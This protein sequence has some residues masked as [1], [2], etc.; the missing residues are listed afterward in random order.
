MPIEVGIWRIDQQLQRVPFSALD[1][2]SRLEH[3]LVKEIS[4]LSPGLMVIGQQ[5]PTAHGHFIDI[6]AMDAD[7]NLI[8]VELKRHRTPREVVAQVLDYASWVQTLSYNDIA[9]L[10]AARNQGDEFEQGFAKAFGG[11]P[12]EKL[13][14]QMRLI[15]VAAELDHASERIIGFLAD[16]YGVPI[17]AVYFRYFKDGDHEYLARTWLIDPQEAEAKIRSKDL[18]EPWNGQ[19][20]YVSYGDTGD[21]DLV[22]EDARNYGFITADGGRWYTRTLERL[23]VGAR[24]FVCIPGSGYVGVGTVTDTVQPISD[25]MV[26]VSGVPTPFVDAPLAGT[27]MKHRA[28]DPELR[29]YFVRVEWIK[30]LPKQDAYWET[31]MYANQNTVTR[32]RNRFTLERLI[33]HFELDAD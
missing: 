29:A 5:V 7:G 17:N 1:S 6:L 24:V 9:E 23:F 15:V 21:N 25:F 33:Q 16:N 12:P 11:N 26:D 22:W 13:N 14:G 10:Y 3:V 19:D 31:G 8:V 32:L 28:D 27:Y 4:I 18:I 2:E 20:F 30:T